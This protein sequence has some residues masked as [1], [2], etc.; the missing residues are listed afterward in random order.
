MSAES[1]FNT[2]DKIFFLES[3]LIFGNMTASTKN[4]E[5]Y[6]V[7]EYDRAYPP[8][9]GWIDPYVKDESAETNYN[10]ILS[11]RAG[12]EKLLANGQYFSPVGWQSLR[13][14]IR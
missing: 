9:P 4:L 6:E 13:L 10:W 2:S 1:S 5:P 3:D 12:L 8:E 14:P 7:Q 11:L